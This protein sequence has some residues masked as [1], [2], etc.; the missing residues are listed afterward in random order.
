MKIIYLY[1]K[2]KITNDLYVWFQ[3]KVYFKYP[4]FDNKYKMNKEMI[5]SREGSGYINIYFFSRKKDG[6]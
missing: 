6:K 3:T 4:Y 5:M 2:R 1:K